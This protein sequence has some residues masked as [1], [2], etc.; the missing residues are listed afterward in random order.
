MLPNHICTACLEQLKINCICIR[1]NTHLVVFLRLLTSITHT[2]KCIF[3]VCYTLFQSRTSATVGRRRHATR[4]SRTSCRVA[5]WFLEFHLS[6]GWI[7]NAG[8][9]ILGRSYSCLFCLALRQWRL[10]AFSTIVPRGAWVVLCLTSGLG[11]CWIRSINRKKGNNWDMV[12]DNG[13]GHNTTV[14]ASL[15][16]LS[17]CLHFILSVFLCLL[18]FIS[19][20]APSSTWCATLS[21]V[22]PA[23]CVT[24]M[25]IHTLVQSMPL[26]VGPTALLSHFNPLCHIPFALGQGG[27]TCVSGL[28]ISLT[29]SLISSCFDLGVTL[30]LAF[31]K[32]FNGSNYNSLMILLVLL[33]IHWSF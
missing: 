19:V 25:R 22:R 16:H 9:N 1:A 20:Y 4:I 17:V 3:K 18:R 21:F 12:L 8:L 30:L 14:C 28:R 10:Y 11:Y 33:E 15:P 23:G 27:C 5:I 7:W 26:C 32:N 6:W 2:F 31:L 24:C 13:C 29:F